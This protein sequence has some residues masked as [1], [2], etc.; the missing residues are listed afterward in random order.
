MT[1]LEGSPFPLLPVPAHSPKET[2]AL[3]LCGAG[4]V[5]GDEGSG[6]PFIWTLG[7]CGW[8]APTNDGGCRVSHRG[9]IRYWSFAPNW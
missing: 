5:G 3:P 4:G 7:L 6:E 2:E 8:E 1:I 9:V